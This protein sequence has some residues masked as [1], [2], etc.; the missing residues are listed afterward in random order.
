MS[1][2]F[3]CFLKKALINLKYIIDY[4]K[5]ENNLQFFYSYYCEFFFK[6]RILNLKKELSTI[7][8]DLIGFPPLACSWFKFYE[9]P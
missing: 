3:H 7:Y 6:E 2:C 5:M 1:L 9:I 4:I 8:W